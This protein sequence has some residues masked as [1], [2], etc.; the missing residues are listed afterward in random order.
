MPH[1]TWLASHSPDRP[2]HMFEIWASYTEEVDH[3][4]RQIGDVGFTVSFIPDDDDEFHLHVYGYTYPV[5]DGW[6][7]VDALYLRLPHVA[8]G[9]VDPIVWTG[10]SYGQVVTPVLYSFSRNC[11][12]VGPTVE[13][14]TR[15][16]HSDR[17]APALTSHM[18][19]LFLVHNEDGDAEHGATYLDLTHPP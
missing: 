2:S 14:G 7:P 8:R 15:V 11:G 4:D 17:P 3:G 5:V 12:H 19:A 18:N 10:Q 9:A 6:S 13:K 16:Y 1:G